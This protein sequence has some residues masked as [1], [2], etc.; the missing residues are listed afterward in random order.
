MNESP[1]L[2]QVEKEE[3][4]NEE[5][6]E[7]TT[8]LTEDEEEKEEESEDVDDDEEEGETESE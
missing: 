4:A 8:E 3:I 7:G 1:P 2:P 5:E 6:V